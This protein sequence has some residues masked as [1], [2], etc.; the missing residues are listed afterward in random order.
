MAA[1]RTLASLP[2]DK[3]GPSPDFPLHRLLRSLAEL[4]ETEGKG[5]PPRPQWVEGVDQESGEDINSYQDNPFLA[6]CEAVVK[7]AGAKVTSKDALA[8]QIIR[9]VF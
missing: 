7:L 6:L 2:V 1:A 3:G 9:V 8:K 5:S 4:W